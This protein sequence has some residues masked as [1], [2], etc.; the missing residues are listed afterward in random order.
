M[1]FPYR[2]STCALM[3]STLTMATP[4]SAEDTFRQHDAHVHGVVEFNIAQDGK[5]LL[6]EITAPGADVV[7]FEHAPTNKQQHQQLAS[8]IAQLN[9]AG[10]LFA[11]SS[12]SNCHLVDVHVTETLT[13]DDGHDDHAGDDHDEH[14]HD[15]HAEHDH[16]EHDHDDHA[17]HDHDEHD[18]DSHAEHDHDEHDHDSHTGHEHDEHDHDSHAGH[19]HDEHNHDSHAGHGEFSAQY[20]FRCD[21]IE[22]LTS[23]QVNWFSHFPTTEK[24]TV[25]AITDTNQS[26]AQLTPTT[27]VF[28]F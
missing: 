15:S 21:N 23:L 4:A 20:V 6:M 18:H 22:Q 25:Q 5:D 13:A 8:A 26:A 19:D 12:A 17:G 2:L 11:F 1:A 7:G 24:I 9:N 27:T 10:E 28:K 14:D 16:D 3:L